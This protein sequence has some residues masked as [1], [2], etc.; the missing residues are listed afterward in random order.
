MSLHRAD[1]SSMATKHRTLT[2]EAL[3]LIAKRFSVL[4][5]P[6]RLR[7]LRRLFDG[8]HS[9]GQLVELTQGTQANVSRHL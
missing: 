8:E 5:E 2:D 6:M 1:H 9:V 3:V 4:S 7:L